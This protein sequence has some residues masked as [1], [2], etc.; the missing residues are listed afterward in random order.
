MMWKI[1]KK[2]AT[3]KRVGT[4]ACGRQRGIKQLSYAATEVCARQIKQTL[5]RQQQKKNISN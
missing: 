3:R 4:W 1:S 2:N 5:Q